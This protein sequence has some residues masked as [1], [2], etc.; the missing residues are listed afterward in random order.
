MRAMVLAVVVFGGSACGDDG[1]SLPLDSA[2]DVA[3]P[4]ADGLTE[5]A[6]PP[7]GSDEPTFAPSTDTL[8][9]EDDFDRYTDLQ[10]MGASSNTYGDRTQDNR[11]TEDPDTSHY[12]LLMP[13]RDGAGNRLRSILLDDPGH[14]QQS[15]VWLSPWP[16]SDRYSPESA[17][18]VFDL[19]FRV[20]VGG[21]PGTPGCKWFQMWHPGGDRTQVG[22]DRGTTER[23][24]WGM[25]PALSGGINRTQQPVGPYWDELNDAQWHRWALLYKPNTSWDYP[26]PSS[27]DGMIRVWIDGVKILDYSQA[28]VGVVP[29]GGRGSWCNQDD[30]DAIPDQSV[31][32]LAWPWVFNGTDVGFTIDYDDLRWWQERE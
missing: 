11:D 23:P 4:D 28:T 3:A 12:A 14:A 32:Y 24:L 20:S 1:A 10:S 22:L 21:T 31:T 5:A 27:R 19:W 30:V 18:I 8:I 17:T 15:S 7:P 6:Q 13:G 26:N 25:E 9:W 16:A 2:V 29:R